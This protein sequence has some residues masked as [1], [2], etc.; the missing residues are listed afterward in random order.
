MWRI[1]VE[2]EGEPLALE[3]RRRIFQPHVRAR[4]ERR[5]RGS[6]L[7]LAICRE[8]VERHG[9][10]IG[11]TPAADGSGNCFAFTLRA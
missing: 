4:G 11:A 3:D 6:G 8:I 1:R 7:G 9:G 5:A 10:Q 2:S